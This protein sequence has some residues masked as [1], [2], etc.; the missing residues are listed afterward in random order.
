MKPPHIMADQNNGNEALWNTTEDRWSR[1]AEPLRKGPLCRHLA[2]DL[3]PRVQ[4]RVAPA[5]A[6]AARRARE[7]LGV[8]RGA[9]RAKGV[10]H[11]PIAT[12]LSTL[13]CA[14]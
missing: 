2:Q 6:A 14:T 12:H 8:L 9:R 11:T 3:R 1:K 4:G 10:S 7:S 13:G 5:A